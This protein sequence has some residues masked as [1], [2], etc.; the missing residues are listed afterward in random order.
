MKKL[1]LSIFTFISIYCVC[2]SQISHKVDSLQAIDT[3]FFPELDTNTRVVDQIM[4]EFPGGLDSLIAF[5][6]EHIT[7]PESL[8]KDN[9]RGDLVIRFCIDE[10]GVAGNVGFIKTLHPDLEK[11]CIQM[12]KDLPQFKPGSMLKR[13][14]KGLYWGP[15]KVWSMMSI[16]FSPTKNYPFNKRIVITP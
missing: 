2:T 12:V 3:I 15:S 7:Y 14:K 16:Y 13:S 9:V 5:V 8:I 4:P 6:K 1:F 11:Q 10:K